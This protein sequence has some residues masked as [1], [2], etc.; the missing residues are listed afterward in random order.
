MILTKNDRMIGIKYNTMMVL[1]TDIHN[2]RYDELQQ[3]YEALNLRTNEKL[4]SKLEEKRNIGEMFTDTIY[5]D[6]L[7]VIGD[8]LTNRP[9]LIDLFV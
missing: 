4:V 8:Y 1:M 9:E 2:R 6:I 5:V 3:L 7:L